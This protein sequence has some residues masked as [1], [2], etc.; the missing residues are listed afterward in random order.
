MR[1]KKR[2][3]RVLRPLCQMGGNL[4]GEVPFQQTQQSLAVAGFVLCHLVNGVVDGIQTVLLC[5]QRQVKLA[6]G[7]TELAVHTPCQILS[8]GAGHVGLQGG[9]QHLCKLGSVL[10]FFVGSLLP[11]QADF[12]IALPMGDASHAQVHTNLAALAGEV[13]LQLLQNP[14][15]V[16]FGDVG[17]V[18]NG[19][20]VD[21]Q[22]MLGSQLGGIQLLELGAIH[23]ADGALEIGG[24][25]LAFVDVT[26]NGADKLLH[27][28]FLQI[29]I[30]F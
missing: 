14:L 17:V 21:A 24:H 3:K 15:L 18:G 29:L 27:N 13:G 26:A 23:L 19:L 16:G 7:G 22:L 2:A 28:H 30:I 20:L 9:A 10:G 12:G 5:L 1:N 8:G 6:L 4:L 25:F 11:V